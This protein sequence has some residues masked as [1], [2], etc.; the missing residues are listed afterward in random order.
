MDKAIIIEDYSMNWAR[1]FE[2]EK[3]KLTEILKDRIQSIEHIGSTA[4]EGLGAK[5]V[6]DIAAGVNNLETVSEFIEPLKQIHYEFVH[7]KEFPQRRFFRKGQ[8]RAGTHHL[9]FYEFE[10]EHWNNQL[11][12][13]DYLRKNPDEARKYHELKVY[14]AE[15]YR[16]DR[17]AYTENKAPFIQKTLLARRS[18]I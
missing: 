4:V 1:Q 8:R 5:P 2:Q 7:H 18:E 14:L 11:L 17:V 10:G 9:H 16:F 12:F 15:K 3:I 6:I 13:R